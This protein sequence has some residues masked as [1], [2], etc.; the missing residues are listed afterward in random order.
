[1]NDQKA[2]KRYQHP[3]D[4]SHIAVIGATLAP[5]TETGRFDSF[6]AGGSSHSRTA[7]IWSGSTAVQAE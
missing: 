5:M 1:M 4:M 7:A 2:H 6:E 3:P